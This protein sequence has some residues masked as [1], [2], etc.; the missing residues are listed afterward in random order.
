MAKQATP[1]FD[2]ILVVFLILAVLI[3][4]W[5]FAPKLLATG[6]QALPLVLQRV[7]SCR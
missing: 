5:V 2:A 1:I 4:L 3:G 7:L 6:C